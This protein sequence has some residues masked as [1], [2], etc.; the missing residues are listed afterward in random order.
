VPRR[1]QEGLRHRRRQSGTISLAILHHRTHV[2]L[3]A[4]LVSDRAAISDWSVPVLSAHIASFFN[5]ITAQLEETS[6]GKSSSHHLHNVKCGI[7][8]ILSLLEYNNNVDEKADQLSRT[9]SSYISS[10]AMISSGVEDWE[11]T[12]DADRL[13]A[14]QEALAGFRLAVEHSKP[15]PRV[16]ALG[17]G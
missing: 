11:M 13:H 2:W 10:H 3:L 4:T 7:A 8:N 6:C 14:A 9:A 1:A 12:K 17:L 16:R 5:L 15:N